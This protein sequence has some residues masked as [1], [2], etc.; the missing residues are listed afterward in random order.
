[1]IQTSQFQGRLSS[2]KT[3]CSN[4]GFQIA[5]RQIGS[6][7]TSRVWAWRDIVCK[8]QSHPSPPG[9]NFINILW[10]AFT[11][12]DLKSVK[13]QSSCHYLFALLGSV[14]IEAGLVALW[15]CGKIIS[16]QKLF[17]KCWWNWLQEEN[18]A[19]VKREN[20]FIHQVS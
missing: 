15:L 1:M 16:A 14:R 17:V 11:I 20:N 12:E 8:I 4:F 7:P 18:E 6:L 10:A 9:V 19:L 5:G 13:I 2:N 3:A